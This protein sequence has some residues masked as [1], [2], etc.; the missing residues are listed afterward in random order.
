LKGYVVR[1][2]REGSP[3]HKP[4]EKPADKSKSRRDQ[5]I[6]WVVLVVALGTAIDNHSEAANA[7]E[8]QHVETALEAAIRGLVRAGARS[9]LFER[10]TA[11]ADRP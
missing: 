7:G 3:R 1:A 8:L 6:T 9:P 4:G 2:A 11:P 10:Y 5:A